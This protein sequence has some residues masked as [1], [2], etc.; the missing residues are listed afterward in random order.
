MSFAE[1]NTRHRTTPL[2][3][4]YSVILTFIIK[5]KHFLDMQFLQKIVQAAD[6][7]GRFASTRTASAVELL[8]FCNSQ[9][10]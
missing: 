8:L 6:F 1:V 7:P 2:S 4:L 10:E 3:L 5:V 9:L